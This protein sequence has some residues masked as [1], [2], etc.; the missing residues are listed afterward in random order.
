MIVEVA[1]LQGSRVVTVVVD[2]YR[3]RD[4]SGVGLGVGVGVGVGLGL[5][6]S[7]RWPRLDE[8]MPEYKT[9]STLTR[10]L[11]LTLTPTLTLTLTRTCPLTLPLTQTWRDEMSK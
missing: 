1:I 11:G 6:F 9:Y 5:R 8:I 10:S 2:L 3:G 7:E 4:R